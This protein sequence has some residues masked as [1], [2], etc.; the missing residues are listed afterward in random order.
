VAP[1]KRVE[2]LVVSGN[3]LLV[4]DALLRHD[5]APLK[6]QSEAVAACVRKSQATHQRRNCLCL[7]VSLHRVW[8]CQHDEAQ[9]EARAA[10]TGAN[11]AHHTYSAFQSAF[12]SA[13]RSAETAHE[14]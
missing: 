1:I 8:N 3:G 4:N 9:G 13:F 7:R 12:Q 2:Y 10:R 5:P 11:R 6:G 14:A